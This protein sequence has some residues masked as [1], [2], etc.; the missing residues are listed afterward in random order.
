MIVQCFPAVPLQ[1][2]IRQSTSNAFGG[3]STH[4]RILTHLRIHAPN[5]T[6][7]RISSS[8]HITI[9]NYTTQPRNSKPW[10]A[11]QTLNYTKL[12]HVK[13]LQSQKHKKSR[14]MDTKE[15]ENQIVHTKRNCCNHANCGMRSQSRWLATV[16]TAGHC[17]NCDKLKKLPAS[18]ETVSDHETNHTL[19]KTINKPT[20]ITGHYER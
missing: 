5:L 10:K 15:I 6:H 19:I 1:P 20:I 8:Y 4:L 17:R 12:H 2:F 7:L 14:G 13:Y 18:T 3:Q 11:W 9:K 16:E